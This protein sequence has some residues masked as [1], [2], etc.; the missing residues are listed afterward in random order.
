MANEVVCKERLRGRLR[1]AVRLPNWRT[2]NK[3][4]R[5]R[6]RV[7]TVG[8]FIAKINALKSRLGSDLE[9]QDFDGEV[10]PE[11]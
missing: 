4:A 8:P 7:I 3:Q 6:A 5:Q 2:F 1:S 10:S 9:Y 11:R